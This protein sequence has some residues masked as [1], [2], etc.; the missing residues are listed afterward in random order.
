LNAELV[1]VEAEIRKMSPPPRATSLAGRGR[2]ADLAALSL[3]PAEQE[4][5]TNLVN[6]RDAITK[7]LAGMDKAKK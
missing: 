5:F 2:E 1:K 4:R 3:T 6:R 7:Q